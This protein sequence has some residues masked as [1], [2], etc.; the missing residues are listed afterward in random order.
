MSFF[1]G[2]YPQ[3]EH[4]FYMGWVSECIT[5]DGSSHLLSPTQHHLASRWLSRYLIIK[6]GTVYLFKVPPISLLRSTKGRL[7]AS[8]RRNHSGSSGTSLGSVGSS[9]SEATTSSSSSSS[10]GSAHFS[11][12][13]ASESNDR[14]A[15]GRPGRRG[16]QSERVQ[17]INRDLD[18]QLAAEAMETLACYK[19]DFRTVHLKEA[20]ASG[21]KGHVFQLNSGTT[22]ATTKK[23]FFSTENAANL[24]S[25]QQAWTRANY[26]SVI[27]FK[28]KTFTVVL[29]EENVFGSLI[30]DWRFGFSFYDPKRKQY[31]WSYKFHQLRSSFDDGQS[32]LSLTFAVDGS[33]EQTRTHVLQSAALPVLLC[34]TE[35]F[36]A[37]KVYTLC[38]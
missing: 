20:L 4:I 32:R 21:L 18:R 25:L 14:L 28:T 24:A 9:A 13:H 19:T 38:L 16:G 36:L 10:T 17:R 1:N 5:P 2:Q 12:S 3:R 22:P 30:L 33:P 34:C 11:L 35:A 15:S 6:G 8:S 23:R 29:E 31:L 27:H 7:V 26:H 37:A